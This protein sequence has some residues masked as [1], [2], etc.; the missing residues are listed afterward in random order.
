[1]RILLTNDDGIDSPGLEALR[2]ELSKNPEHEIW[3]IAPD[4]ERSGMSHYITLK[5][6][7]KSKNISD[8]TFSLS[9][10]PADCV[11]TAVLGI[12][13]E[14]PDIVLSGINL[15]PN[16]GTDLVYSGTAAAAR[17]A[18]YM[19]I[20]GVALSIHAYSGPWNF[21]ALACFAAKNLELFCK[22]FDR[23]HFI[24]VN[25]P[26]DGKMSA[27]IEITHPCYRSYNDRMVKFT[28]PRGEDYWF[29]KGAP[30]D[31]SDEEGSDWN[32]VV[33][34]SISVSPIHLHPLNN[35]VDHE[36]ELAQFK[37]PDQP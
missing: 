36:Y 29:L 8:R 5:E 24:N 34:G 25:A 35:M 16:L 21:G 14:K 19:G 12:M 18:A 20:P 2:H 11:M 15:G 6:P 30:I 9:G 32:A 10:S 17:Q 31:N 33:R 22:F 23:Q 26:H 27:P 13:A 7:I 4:G 37:S 3:V 28:A 1:M